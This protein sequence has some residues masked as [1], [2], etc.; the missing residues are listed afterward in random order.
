[1]LSSTQGGRHEGR[2]DRHDGGRRH[3]DKQKN[4]SRQIGRQEDISRQIGRQEDISGHIGT[5]KDK[6][7]QT[8]READQWAGHKLTCYYI[9]SFLPIFHTKFPSIRP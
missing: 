8:D 4:I 7:K 1:M 2:I 9:F 3:I 6:H 5:Q